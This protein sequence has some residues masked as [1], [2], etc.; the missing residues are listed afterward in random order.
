M[1]H[2][3]KSLKT[4]EQIVARTVERIFG[5]LGDTFW[6]T[7]TV[8]R[9]KSRKFFERFVH[10]HM[11]EKLGKENS[12]HSLKNFRHFFKKIIEEIRGKTGFLNLQN[13]LENWRRFLRKFKRINSKI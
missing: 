4:Q 8:L 13:F 1:E 3:K 6:R 12:R 9:E 2:S 7:H 11:L 5:Q 10:M